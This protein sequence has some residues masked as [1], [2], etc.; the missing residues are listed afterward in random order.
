[1]STRA[2]GVA[3]RSE[4]Q[5]ARALADARAYLAGD[6]TR[7]LQTILGGIWLLDGCLQFQAFMYS[8][9]FIAM[10]AGNAAGQP[11]WIAN[12]VT[13]GAHTLQHNQ[14][15]VN[16]AFALIQVTIGIG[17]LYRPTVKLAIA[18]SCAWALAVWWFGEAFGMM[19]M[20]MA[21]PLTGAPGAVL[22]YALVGLLVW[23][24]AGPGGLL[25]ERGARAAW[26]ALW[27][28]MAYLWLQAPSSNPGAISALLTHA[29]SGMVWLSSAQV[30]V[31]N[32]LQGG[33]T[34]VAFILA[35]L[36]AGIAIAVA[37]GWRARA[38][39][40]LAIAL[41]LAYWVLGQG[42]GGIFQGG[43]TDPNAGPLFVLLAALMWSLPAKAR[44]AG[45]VSPA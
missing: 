3:R 33:G 10:L 27:L 22:L 37:L 13:W 14:A 12:S 15:A 6:T 36:S 23:P 16:T 18:V 5:L 25:R 26:C 43:A 45:A 41:S 21:S 40:A 30:D 34:A 42:F 4:P 39:L 31:A 44:G 19:F 8:H 11:A 32:A 1:L 17:L 2:P 7:A 38:F 29:P 35:A 24:G 20:A 9:G 28:V